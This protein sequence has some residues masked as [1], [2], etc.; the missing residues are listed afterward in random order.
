[1]GMTVL[2]RPTSKLLPDRHR[3]E[4]DRVTPR[5]YCSCAATDLSIWVNLTTLLGETQVQISTLTVR[6]ADQTP[7]TAVRE[8]AAAHAGPVSGLPY[9]CMP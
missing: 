9:R 5:T 2:S 1:M 8:A 4:F 6:C 7:I 3:G